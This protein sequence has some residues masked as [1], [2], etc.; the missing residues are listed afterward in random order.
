[1]L[2]QSASLFTASGCGPGGHQLR[3]VPRGA[4]SHSDNGKEA[5]GQALQVTG[6]AGYLFRLI[7]TGLRP[8]DS[9]YSIRLF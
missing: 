6:L 2:E 3:Q 7:V 4:G 9:G 5:V 1:M 8:I